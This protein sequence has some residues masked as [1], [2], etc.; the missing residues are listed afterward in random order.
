[1]PTS[2]I[3]NQPVLTPGRILETGLAF[4]SSK[5]LLTAVKLDLFTY[6][7][8]DAKTAEEI[9]IEYNLHQRG[10][11]DFLDTLV[12]LQFLTREGQGQEA[13]YSNTPE[14][15]LFLNRGEP[16]YVGGMLVMANDRLYPFW[17]NL[18]EALVTGKPQNESKGGGSS[19]FEALYA[20]EQRLEGFVAAMGSFQVAN[21]VTFARQFDFSSYKTH[22]DIGGAGGHFSAQVVAFNPSIRSISFDLPAVANI[23][24]RN[25]RAMNIETSVEV[26][27]GDFFKDAFPKAD[28]ITMG[29]ILHDWDLATKKMLI[30][31]AYD[32]LPEGGAFAAIENVIDDKREQNAFGLMMSLNMLIETDGG[33]DYTGADFY[34]WAK[35]AGFKTMKV[36]H[37]AGPTSALVVYK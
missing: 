24:K 27:S 23:A 35:E 21:F 16:S 17:N 7:S 18:E 22:C 14:T 37:L 1:M 12:A 26:V 6:L 20:D 34:T 25:L 36:M 8:K 33:F 32:A 13:L 11:Y 30:K 15:S 31:K 5:V 9:R 3:T 2:A 10:I 4:W 19:L 29:N 28:V